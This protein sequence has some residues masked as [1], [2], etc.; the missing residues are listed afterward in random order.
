M[1]NFK[2]IGKQRSIVIAP[3]QNLDSVQQSVNDFKSAE[4]MNRKG[5]VGSPHHTKGFNKYFPQGC[6]KSVSQK[7][8]L[9]NNPEVRHNK[10]IVLSRE[11]KEEKLA[12]KKAKEECVN[13][14]KLT[15]IYS[16]KI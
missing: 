11:K 3:N 16:N 2:I 7:I 15:T 6:S 10:I 8:L 5:I 13:K 1:S 12:I 9:Q 14:N 4:I